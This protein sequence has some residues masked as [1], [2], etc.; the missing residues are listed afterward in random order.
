MKTYHA[1][2]AIDLLEEEEKK[3]SK[4]WFLCHMA[5][6]LISHDP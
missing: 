6:L 3:K 5:D 1:G 4:I 2:E